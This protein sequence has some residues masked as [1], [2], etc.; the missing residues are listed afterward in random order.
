MAMRCRTGLAACLVG[1]WLLGA[2][3]PALA[4]QLADLSLEELLDV[5]LGQMA[6]SGIHHTHDQ[7]EWMV[8]YHFMYMD[9]DGNLDGTNGVSIQDVFADGFAVAPRN[10]YMEM[11]MFHVMY[12]VTEEIT[13]MLVVP[14]IR[15]AMDHER[16]DGVRF[17]TRSRGLGDIRLTGLYS[18][19]HNDVNRVILQGGLSFPTGSINETDNLPGMMSMPGS[20][21]R[22]PYPMQL[23]SGTFDL[24]PGAT[25]LGQVMRWG[26]GANGQGTVRLGEN[27][28]DYRLGSEYE[29]SAWGARKLTDWT[30]GSLR[31]RWKQWFNIH[32]RDPALNP[33]MVPTADPNLRAGRRLD[34]LFGANVF[35]PD[36]PL[37]GFRAQVEAGLPVYQWLKGPQLETD[38]LVSVNL[39]WTF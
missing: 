15:K 14:Y 2:A 25:Y 37:E 23:G 20:I 13:A 34:L 22:L 6:I 1:M 10:M 18:L 27:E 3:M 4:N 26:W 17:T 35:A 29:L 33:N 31:L 32:G 12:G 11:H 5:Q 21:Q 16:M 28:N 9:M 30:S 19:Y 7:G 36:G 39:E 24:L 38:A 8:G